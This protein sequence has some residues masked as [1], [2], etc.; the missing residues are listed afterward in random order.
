MAD[1][2]KIIDLLYKI[3]FPISQKV[4]NY[5]LPTGLKDS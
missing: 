5:N 4:N 1:N 3:N 2:E